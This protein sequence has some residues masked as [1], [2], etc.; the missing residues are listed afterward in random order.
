M[1]KGL[2]NAAKI[3]GGS[4][5]LRAKIKLLADGQWHSTLELSEIDGVRDCAPATTISELRANGIPIAR[6]VRIT[7]DHKRIYEYRLGRG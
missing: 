4:K 2:I 7:E 1:A 6:R 3:S 5:R